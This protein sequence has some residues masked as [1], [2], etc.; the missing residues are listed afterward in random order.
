MRIRLLVVVFV[1]V[2]IV[3]CGNGDVYN[4][5]GPLTPIAD[6]VFRGRPKLNCLGGRGAQCWADVGDTI[7][8]IIADEP[9]ELRVVGRVW[10]K[11]AADVLEAYA[12]QEREFM[13][14]Y[15]N[16]HVCQAAEAAMRIRDRRWIVGSRNLALIAYELDPG[17]GASTIRI[18][19]YVGSYTCKE[20]FAVPLRL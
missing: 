13:N 16:G 19:W 7:A 11:P 3:G 12:Q 1:L 2:A 20:I 18:V 8:Y 14:R 10:E 15:G 9:M 17:L 5:A 4:W 6:S